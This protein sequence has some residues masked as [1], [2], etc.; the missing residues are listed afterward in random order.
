VTSKN[1]ALPG[2]VRTERATYRREIDRLNRKWPRAE[3]D[4]TKSLSEKPLDVET[5]DPIPNMGSDAGR[6]FKRQIL[7][8]DIKDGKSGGFRLLY[9]VSPDRMSVS[10]M[11]IYAKVEKT[12]LSTKALLRLIKQA[13]EHVQPG[14]IEIE[15]S[16][17]N[18]EVWI[19]GD[20]MDIAPCTIPLAPGKH[21]IKCQIQ[22][23]LIAEREFTCESGKTER[24]EIHLK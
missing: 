7:S 4:V 19:D 5:G 13:E 8:S 21:S 18:A 23:H 14:N 9:I 1:T 12:N 10:L 17:A 20:F 2:Y 22:P 11:S 3:S 24:M 16:P 15:T 6:V